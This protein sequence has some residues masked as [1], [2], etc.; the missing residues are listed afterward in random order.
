MISTLVAHNLQ[1]ARGVY[2]H[3]HAP[4]NDHNRFLAAVHDEFKQAYRPLERM[5]PPPFDK[6]GTSM[7]LQVAD[8]LRKYFSALG[9][10]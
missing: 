5:A 2:D 4:T 9:V 3:F 1:F 8:L 10:I 6:S 7:E